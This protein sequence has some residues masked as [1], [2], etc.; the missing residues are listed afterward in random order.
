MNRTIVIW[1]LIGVAVAC[2]W[3]GLGMILGPSYNL[4]RSNFVAITAPASLI[5]RQMPIKMLS[6]VLLN[7]VVYAA[8][9]LQAASLRRSH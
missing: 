8:V 9:G 3:V 7:G 6:F 2:F 5:G 4:G 1:M